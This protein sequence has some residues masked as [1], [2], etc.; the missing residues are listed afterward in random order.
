MRFEGEKSL[1]KITLIITGRCQ[2]VKRTKESGSLAVLFFNY[3]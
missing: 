2:F 1:A 3:V